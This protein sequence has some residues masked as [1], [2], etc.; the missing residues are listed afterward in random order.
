[1]E[2]LCQTTRTSISTSKSE[3]QTSVLDAMRNNFKEQGFSDVGK[4]GG[5]FFDEVKIKEGLLFGLSSWE[6]VG[7]V[8]LENRDVVAPLLALEIF[9]I[10]WPHT[11]YNFISRVSLLIFGI[12]VHIF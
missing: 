10:A 11:F 9:K 3:W 2:E 4:L 8:D 1:M 12:H 7:F 5:L 6:L